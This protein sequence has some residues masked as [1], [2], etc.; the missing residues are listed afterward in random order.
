MLTRSVCKPTGG[1]VAYVKPAGGGGFTNFFAFFTIIMSG[2]L[3][4][5]FLRDN[6]LTAAVELKTAPPPTAQTGLLLNCVEL[7]MLTR[8]V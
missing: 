8:S 4:K 3:K 7:G 2:T 6:P 5:N 1:R